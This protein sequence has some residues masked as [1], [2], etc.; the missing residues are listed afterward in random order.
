MELDQCLEKRASYRTYNDKQ[1]AWEDLISVLNAAR[2]APSSGNLQNWSFII[3]QKQEVREE[4]S[5]AALNQVW[6]NQAPILIV[7]CSRMEN[8]KRHYGDRGERLYAIQN[9][10]AAI[11]NILLKTAD[12]GIA[13]CWVNAFDDEAIKRIL[14]IPETVVPQGI[15]TIGYSN[16]RVEKMKRYDLDLLLHFDEWN[17]KK[18]EG[19]FPLKQHS[20]EL[21]ETV[22]G[23]KEKGKGFFANFLSRFKKR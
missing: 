12:L 3:V 10:A 18:V 1:V 16:E 6:I 5:K 11:N 23:T 15:I 21:K 19:L 4:I 8:V 2:L 20:K 9:C 14:K 7:V 22:L 17:G 13:S